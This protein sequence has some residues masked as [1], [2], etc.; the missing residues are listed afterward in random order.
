MR[1]VKFAILSLLSLFIV[2]TALSLLFPSHLR[3][4]RAVNVA[5]SQAR[6]AEVIADLQSWEQWNRFV[7]HT[8]LTNKRYSSPSSGAGAS[9]SSDQFTI[10]ETAADTNGI[11]LQWDLKGGKRYSGGFSL[12][13]VNGDS[14]AV[15]WWFDLSFRWYPWEK[16]GVFVYDRKL[17]P[18]MEESLDSLREFLKNSR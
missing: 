18:V 13:P 9:L 5:A 6:T 3:V 4:S 11:T 16:M 10:R 2:L 15:Q 12:L 7:R 17:G 8:P 1:F 14:L